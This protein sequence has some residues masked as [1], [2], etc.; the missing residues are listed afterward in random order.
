VDRVGVLGGLL[1]DLRA[2]E[3]LSPSK[4]QI[5]NAGPEL[6]AEPPNMF[7]NWIFSGTHTSRATGHPFVR[8]AQNT[9][10]DV[11]VRLDLEY[12]LATIPPDHKKVF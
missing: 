9:S 7:W 5:A 6:T 4:L 3:K 12:D 11:G 10:H 1:L 2:Q 8:L